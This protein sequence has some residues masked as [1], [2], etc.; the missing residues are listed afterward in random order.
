M[1][2]N[3]NP[4]DEKSLQMLRIYQ[5]NGAIRQNTVA[6]DIGL[7]PGKVTERRKALENSG[8]IKKFTIEIDYN[9]LGYHTIGF[10]HLSI[11]DKSDEAVKPIV[12][13]MINHDNIIEVHEIFGEE[14]D[15]F[16]KIMCKNNEELRN[17][18]KELYALDNV[19][20]S[21]LYTH[22]VAQTLKDE[23]GVPI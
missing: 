17:V 12:D 19:V 3:G 23:P 16:I 14:H 13:Y 9:L 6:S 1:A 2:A 15:F 20:T 10:F 8:I 21:K 11:S 4:P 22:P 5:E 18:G 7:S